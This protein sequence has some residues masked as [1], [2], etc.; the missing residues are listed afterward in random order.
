MSARFLFVGEKPSPTA[1]RNGWTWESGH[2]AAK[3]LFE[4]LRACDVDPTTC[5][6]T[7]LFGDH[8]N[9]PPTL[10][11][12]YRAPCLRA[13]A[14]AGTPV[15]A[16]GQKV[17][18]ALRERNV[19]HITIRHPAARGAGRLRARYAEHVRSILLGTATC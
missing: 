6:F 13:A 3:S 16:M 2:L 8:H 11:A 19:P 15:V 17:S 4:A 12:N 14:A 7:N 10:T 1:V 18:R 9:S 5:G